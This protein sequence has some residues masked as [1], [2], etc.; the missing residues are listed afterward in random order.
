MNPP[1]F[2]SLI[3][4]ITVLVPFL[5]ILFITRRRNAKTKK[6]LAIVMAYLESEGL[7]PLEELNR[8]N[9][10]EVA[11]ILKNKKEVVYDR[12]TKE[13]SRTSSPSPTS[14]RINRGSSGSSPLTRGE[15]TLTQETRIIPRAG[16]VEERR[17]VP[18]SSVKNV[19]P[20]RTKPS[21]SR[22]VR[23]HR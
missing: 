12:T 4:A 8:L 14:G 1:L 3:G 10:R 18:V 20:D 7:N 15:P 9:A 16:I 21:T 22:K 13:E 5:I 11:T 19:E 2:Y 17:S 6:D 23:L